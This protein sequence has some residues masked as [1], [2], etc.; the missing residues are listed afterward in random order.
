M[1]VYENKT[2]SKKNHEQNQNTTDKWNQ[3]LPLR[4]QIKG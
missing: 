3:M 4:P 1:F 2:N